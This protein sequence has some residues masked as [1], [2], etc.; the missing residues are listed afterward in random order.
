MTFL[1]S[2]AGIAPG[3]RREGQ[4]AP[5]VSI[6]SITFYK[7]PEV[8]EGKV[9]I[10]FSEIRNDELAQKTSEAFKQKFLKRLKENEIE[11]TDGALADYRIRVKLAYIVNPSSVMEVRIDYGELS[12][13]K[14]KQETP[15]FEKNLMARSSVPFKRL[16]IAPDASEIWARERRNRSLA[17]HFADDLARYFSEK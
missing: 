5:K 4:P 16:V 2:C 8:K 1:A 15:V 10:D 14:E 3:A 17:E 13:F 11:I 9:K 6:E 7:S 12:V